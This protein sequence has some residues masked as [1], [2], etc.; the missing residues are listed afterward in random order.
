MTVEYEKWWRGFGQF[1]Q[2]CD[3]L[4]G[5]ALDPFRTFGNEIWEAQGL[6]GHEEFDELTG[7]LADAEDSADELERELDEL[8]EQI[9][10]ALEIEEPGEALEKI[11]KLV[12]VEA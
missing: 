10:S 11:R 5:D 1:L 7:K 6:V 8:R 2:P 4:S 3:G 9:E 12:G